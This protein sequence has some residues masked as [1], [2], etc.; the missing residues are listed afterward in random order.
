MNV[1]NMPARLVCIIF[2]AIMLAIIQLTMPY[3]T[4]KKP[5]AGSDCVEVINRVF[6]KRNVRAPTAAEQIDLDN[7]D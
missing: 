1:R 7:C 6:E 4:F 5:R 3:R 2:L